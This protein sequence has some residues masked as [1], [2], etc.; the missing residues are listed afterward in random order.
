MDVSNG[1][2]SDHR[3]IV[4]QQSKINFHFISKN[5]FPI[6]FDVILLAVVQRPDNFILCISQYLTVSICAKI[7]IVPHP[8]DKVIRPLNNWG[9]DFSYASGNASHCCILY[10][11][12]NSQDS[13]FYG[14]RYPFIKIEL[15]LKN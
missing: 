2:A 15:H 6:S 5:C 13:V 4:R 12:K 10:V 9:L 14:Q 1:Y 7:S 11:M 3:L 8:S